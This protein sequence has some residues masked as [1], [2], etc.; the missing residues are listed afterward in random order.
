MNN[1]GLIAKLIKRQSN[2]AYF[3]EIPIGTK[4]IIV[5]N[6]DTPAY[7]LTG[8]FLNIPPQK[9]SEGK[10]HYTGYIEKGTWELIGGIGYI[11]D[12]LKTQP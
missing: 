10:F 2:R 12:E 3:S 7:D 5:D 11:I 8:Y 1:I 4:F 6:I 9:L